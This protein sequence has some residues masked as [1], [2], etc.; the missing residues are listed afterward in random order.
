[1]MTRQPRHERARRID[2]DAQAR[3]ASGGRVGADRGSVSLFLV[4]AVLALFVAV[5]LVV[6][7]GQKLR[8]TQ[9]AD[10]A[11]AEAARAAVQSV[12]PGTTVRGQAP[13]VDPAAAVRAAQAYLSAAGVSGTAT[14]AGDR[15]Q[16]TTSSSFTPAF[17]SLI[18]LGTQT[19]TGR[20]EARLARGVDREQPR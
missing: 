9:R 7:G 13:Q 20:A 16:V 18:G 1:M 19:V 3:P 12:Q 15:V 5:G 8:A 11:A 10:D 4:V 2:P 14:A 6:D 17:L